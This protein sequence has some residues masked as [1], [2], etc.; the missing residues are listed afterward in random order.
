[1]PKATDEL[2]KDHKMIRKILTEWKIGNPRFSQIHETLTRVVLGHAWFE[3]QVFFP[4]MEA[5]PAFARQFLSE[6]YQEHKDID[7][8]L[9]LVKKTPAHQQEQLDFY[10][11]QL[12]C[13]L[14][15][16]FKKEED[17]MFPICEKILTEEGLVN[18]AAEMRARQHEKDHETIS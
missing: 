18:L 9:K 10:T 16:H 15:T 3:D 5:E 7:A 17:A 6:L 11:V 13:V 12:G 2:L 1:M 4:A 14:D 8:L